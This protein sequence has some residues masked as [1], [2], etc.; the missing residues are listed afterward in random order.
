V[1]DDV[2][3]AELRGLPGDVA[4]LVQIAEV[5]DDHTFPPGGVILVGE[6]CRVPD[7]HD[8]LVPVVGQCPCRI[9]AEPARRPGDQNQRHTS[10]V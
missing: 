7:V 9:A 2:E 1:D 8:H 5:P 6:T 3:A 4:D 10:R